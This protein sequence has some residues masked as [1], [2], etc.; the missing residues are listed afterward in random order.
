MKAST[1]G[2]HT[3]GLVYLGAREYWDERLPG[4]L[5]SL[6][7]AVD[8]EQRAVLEQPFLAA[9]WYDVLPIDGL[10]RTAARLAGVTQ[11]QLVRA[12]AAMLAER[13]V[14]GVYRFLLKLASP[15][16][17]AARLPRA[18]LQY[19]DFGAAHGE[20]TGPRTFEAVRS[21]VP[22]ELSTWMSA[23]VEGFA[24]VALAL[25]GARDIEVISGAPEA[26]GHA[27]GH[28]TVTI[29]FAIRWS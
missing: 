14:H 8:E 2:F 21:G 9:S 27:H 5:P 22:T 25:A 20:M 11:A 28:K 16:L 24:P 12:N 17:V 18:A 6:L 26:D 23:C 15:E 19:F 10:S 29:P 7:E 3:K 4:R 13:D 1:G